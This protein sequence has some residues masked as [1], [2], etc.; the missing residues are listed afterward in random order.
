LSKL[1]DGCLLVS[2]VDGTLVSSDIFHPDNVKMIR[3]FESDG[4][5]FIIASG[6]S[7]QALYVLEEKLGKLPV[8]IVCGGAV[9]YDFENKKTLYEKP[10]FDGDKYFIKKVMEEL[11]S[12]GIQVH[13]SNIV[14]VLKDS[15]ELWEHIVYEKLISVP[16]D[17]KTAFN[18]P[19]YKV[20]FVLTNPKEADIIRKIANEFNFENSFVEPTKCFIN[21][22]VQHFLELHPSGAS[23]AVSLQHFIQYNN[24]QNG[25]IFAIGDHFNDVSMMQLAD[26]SA[27]VKEAP[28]EVKACANYVAVG[29]KDGAVADFIGYLYNLKKKGCI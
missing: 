9:I 20:I 24:L 22:R 11:P 1:F 8:S 13:S 6:R 26:V 4:G 2:D 16:A 18:N 21:G 19:W 5:K 14:Y 15:K 25:K 23:K 17:F 12:L 3:K 27:A 10:I 28:D 29:C 7:A